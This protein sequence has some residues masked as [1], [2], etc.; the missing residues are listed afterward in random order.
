MKTRHLY[1]IKKDTMAYLSLKYIYFSIIFLISKDNIYND[2]FLK[3]NF[4]IPL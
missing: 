2:K 3:Y 4:P 1:A